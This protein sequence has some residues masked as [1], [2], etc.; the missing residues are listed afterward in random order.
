MYAILVVNYFQCGDKEL[1]NKLFATKEDA[2][3][4]AKQL[5]KKYI[6][7]RKRI[8]RKEHLR[9]NEDFLTVYGGPS[10]NCL[11][12]EVFYDIQEMELPSADN[13]TIKP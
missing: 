1:V 5:A 12:A 3:N 4:E 8:H 7:D 2:Q 10:D 13:S 9:Y 6:K 11:F